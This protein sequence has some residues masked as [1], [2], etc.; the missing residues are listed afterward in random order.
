MTSKLLVER[1]VIIFW[2]YSSRK[3]VLYSHHLLLTFYYQTTIMEDSPMS[4][5]TTSTI[6][7]PYGQQFSSDET[8]EL[9]RKSEDLPLYIPNRTSHDYHHNNQKFNNYNQ[10]N[11]NHFNHFGYED[12]RFSPTWNRSGTLHSFH[13]IESLVFVWFSIVVMSLVLL[14]CF[15]MSLSSHIY[16]WTDGVSEWVSIFLLTA[17]PVLTSA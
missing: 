1:I 8:D 12:S 6:E 16:F 4:T 13:S 7:I 14:R 5:A 2:H 11:N 15:V 3:N 9:L 17:S 10:F